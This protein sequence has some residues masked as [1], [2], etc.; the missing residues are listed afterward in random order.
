MRRACPSGLLFSKSLITLVF[1][2]SILQSNPST[3]QEWS[4][5]AELGATLFSAFQYSAVKQE[6]GSFDRGCTIPHNEGWLLSYYP[7]NK[8]LFFSLG[9]TRFHQRSVDILVRLD[10]GRTPHHVA[11]WSFNNTI[12][13]SMGHQLDISQTLGL[14]REKL[15]F[16]PLYGIGIEWLRSDW[17]YPVR[18]YINLVDFTRERGINPSV[19]AGFRFSYRHRRSKFSVKALGNLGFRYHA[20]TK[21][22]V[23]L[24]EE[25]ILATTR[26]KNDFL[27]AQASYEY[28]FK[29]NK[30]QKK[31]RVADRI[32][33]FSRTR[34]QEL[35]IGIHPFEFAKN[36]SINY[37]LFPKKKNKSIFLDLSYFNNHYYNEVNIS[38][39]PNHPI[40]NFTLYRIPLLDIRVGQHIFSEKET[41]SK[42]GVGYYLR[43]DIKLAKN[44]AYIDAVK[45]EYDKIP[46]TDTHYTALGLDFQYKWLF[47]DRWSITPII[48]A[49]MGV[50][51]QNSYLNKHQLFFSLFADV[52]ARLYVGYRF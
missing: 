16:E 2:L 42:W 10:G 52:Q 7:A 9:Y 22:R 33:N 1:S 45:E 14:E 3:A 12:L 19:Q 30:V 49:D 6:G 40:Y 27:A 32:N 43:S 41:A 17:V 18:G 26:G 20:E 47:K 4:F 31:E 21:Y 24:P 34:I 37:E 8:K 35:K 50:G 23:F 11:S 36:L 46:N 25:P 39:K 51:N 44:Q 13:L 15:F 5:G 29:S 48:M 38:D 28:I